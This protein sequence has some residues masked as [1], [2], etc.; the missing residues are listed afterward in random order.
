LGR[1]GFEELE[2]YEQFWDPELL[3]PDNVSRE[4]LYHEHVESL[5]TAEAHFVPTRQSLDWYISTNLGGHWTSQVSSASYW[6]QNQSSVDEG[7]QNGSE[8]MHMNAIANYEYPF[9]ANAV[10]DPLIYNNVNLGCFAID[11]ALAS[12]SSDY[13]DLT[14]IGTST[15]SFSRKADEDVDF[16]EWLH[17]DDEKEISA[18]RGKEE[19]S[20]EENY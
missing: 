10:P 4:E 19:P 8:Q 6:S 17:E 9:V 11:T 2:D 14:S 20:E 5:Q 12:C 7:S 1:T 16:N 3:L 15:S 18:K 13:I